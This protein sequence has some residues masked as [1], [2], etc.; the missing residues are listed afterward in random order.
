MTVPDLGS[1]GPRRTLRQLCFQSDGHMTLELLGWWQTRP[2]RR[3]EMSVVRVPL[4]G[5]VEAKS[6]KC[7]EERQDAEQATRPLFI[8][9]M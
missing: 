2:P 9:P 1:A 5:C 8:V 7:G 3:A 6:A 4:E